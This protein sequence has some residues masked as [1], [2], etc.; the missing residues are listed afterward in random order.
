MHEPAAT[1]HSRAGEPRALSREGGFDAGRLVKK[2]GRDEKA[3]LGEA[4]NADAAFA[5][6]EAFFEQQ[7]PARSESLTPE[8]LTVAD[9]NVTADMGNATGVTDIRIVSVADAYTDGF[10]PPRP[11]RI[12]SRSLSAM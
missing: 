9:F 1:R 10:L 6:L 12:S 2:P 4:P 3:Q 11:A 5:T 7:I 8:I